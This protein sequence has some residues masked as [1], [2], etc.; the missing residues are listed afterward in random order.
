[1]YLTKEELA[2]LEGKE[3]KARQFAMEILVKMGESCGAERLIPIESVH[4]VLHAYKS[5]F[6]AG[7]EAAERI[8]EMGGKFTVPTTIDPCGMDTEDWRAARTPEHYAE[9]QTRLNN[10]VMKMGVIP[11]WTC[12]PYYGFNMPRFGQHI[13]WS[14][15]NA[16]SFANTVIG[17]R[18]NRQSAIL[19]ICMGIIGKA[20]EMG[21][22]LDENRRGEILVEMKIDR[23]LKQWEYPALG[24][25][26]GKKL[27]SHIGV[28]NGMKGVPKQDNL[29]S[30]CAAAAASGSVALLHIVG[31]TPE[32][33]TLE[34]AFGGASPIETLLVDEN[35][36][37]ETRAK[38]NTHEG[39]AIDFIALG[40]P[41]YT[42]NEMI[43]VHQLLNGRKIHK[44]VTMWIYAN[45]YAINLAEQMGIRKSLEDSGITIRAE[46]CMIISPL[47]EWGF[48]TIMTDS[49]KCTHYGP[50]ECK[51]DIVFASTEECVE[52][53]V[54]GHVVREA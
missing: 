35:T 18:T 41:H 50:M 47:S 27:G 32:A 21:L 3:G 10:A 9:M 29:K 37:L 53:A 25:Y 30:L 7:V 1:M 13:A 43:R 44:D 45:S 36:L 2:I 22:H 31:I 38:M 48:K 14:E 15:S 5:A 26:L 11:V 16:V 52:S 4:L 40:C 54:A 34:E 8:A 20:P 46:T 6:D 51:T 12:T 33:R 39:D 24:F 23:P 17:A 42:I 19:D 49:G 28:V